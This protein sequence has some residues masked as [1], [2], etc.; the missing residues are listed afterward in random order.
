MAVTIT[1][2]RNGGTIFNEADATTGWTGSL[3]VYTTDPAPVEATG[4]LGA[5]VSTTTNNYY[6]TTGTGIDL[7]DSLI[8]VWVR[9]YGTMD[10]VANGG[11]GIVVGD[12]TNRMAYY[13]GG[14]D[15]VGF[16]HQ[17][18]PVDWVCYLLDTTSLP[19]G[20]ATISGSEGSM[21]WTSIT[22][23][24]AR[25]K[26]LSKALGNTENC[27]IDIIRVGD[28]GL[29][30]TGGGTGTEGNYDEIA[31]ADRSTANQQA[32]G[33][34]RELATGAFGLQGQLVFGDNSGTG[35]VD[36][37]AVGETV[38]FEPPPA[39]VANDR[40]LLS[41]VGNSTGSTS[42]VWTDC[43][44]V[45]P[46]G[47]GAAV[48]ASDADVATVLITGCLFK[49]FEQ[50]LTFSSDAT[51]GPNHDVNTTTFDGCGAITPG[52]VDFTDNVVKNSTVAADTSAVLWNLNLDP[53]NYLAGTS[54]SKGSLAHHAIEFG[55]SAPTTINLEGMVFSGFNASNGQNDSTFH[56]LA[57]GGTVTINLTDCTGNVSYK[58][59]GATVVVQNTVTLKVTVIDQDGTGV[60]GA[61]TAIYTVTGD[62]QLMNEDTVTGG[63]AQESYNYSTDTAVYIR[64]RKSSTGTTRYVP[65]VAGGTIT[66]DGLDVTITLRE[67]G[68]T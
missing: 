32:F 61:Q 6:Y 12:G 20:K 64:V 59:A 26:T 41:I 14:S 16:R 29:Q 30:V 17:V 38:I 33:V 19:T 15:Q 25:F 57:T 1:D 42:V 45:C 27:W 5:V 58:S 13:V 36:F 67:E 43:S 49:G 34:C 4:S 21:A 22:D 35:S 2:L 51:N 62:T 10:T 53:Q 54:I 7:S 48:V 44:F 9:P 56:V 24:G 31:T 8:Y 40:F 39:G 55:T 68:V 47:V 3:T 65:A 63:I 11:V 60:V 50:G 37:E 18:G 28:Q 52:R 23:I 46:A 66:Q